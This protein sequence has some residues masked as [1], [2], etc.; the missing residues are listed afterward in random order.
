M[1]LI[2]ARRPARTGADGSLV[3]LAAQDRTVWDTALTAEGQDLVRSCLR[4]NIPG[5]YQVMAAIN[6]VHSDAPSAAETDWGQILTLY[7]QLLALDPSPVVALNRAVALAE[8]K[9]GEAGLA[10]LEGLPLERYYLFHAVRAD[11][12]RRLGRLPDAVAAYGTAAALTGNA[13]E[14]VFLER[15]RESV[16]GS[17]TDSAPS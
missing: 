1:L 14:R 7:D 3:P 16:A 10:A 8:V 2:A 15:A 6:A 9:G 12:L 13:A 11:L 5:P 4:R 17:M